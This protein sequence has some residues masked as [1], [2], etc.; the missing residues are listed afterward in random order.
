MR[1]FKRKPK[2]LNGLIAPAKKLIWEYWI[3]PWHKL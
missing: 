1:V 2:T 3:K